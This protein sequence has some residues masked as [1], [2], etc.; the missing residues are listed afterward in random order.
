MKLVDKKVKA[1]K[2]E[3]V[4]QPEEEAPAGAEIIDL[5]ELL[6]RSLKGGKKP[7]AKAASKTATKKVATKKT[8][9]ARKAA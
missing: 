9:P 3:T 8:T 6:A 2:T 5:S 4:V 7:A 1:G